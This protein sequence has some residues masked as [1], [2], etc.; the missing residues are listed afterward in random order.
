MSASQ[1]VRPADRAM[2]AEPANALYLRALVTAAEHGPHVSV[3]WVQLAGRHRRLRTARSTR[4]YTVLAG[5]IRFQ[6]GD[7][8]AEHLCAGDLVIVPRGTA[9][10]L[11]GTGTY[12][13]I[14]APA[15]MAGDD[16]Y[17]DE[18]CGAG[19]IIGTVSS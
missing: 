7:Q 8:P 12:L 4:V 13:V 9:Y 10:E 11:A 16:E 19:P 18:H 1:V 14:N 3:T 5:A 6:V 15:F 17:L 2:V